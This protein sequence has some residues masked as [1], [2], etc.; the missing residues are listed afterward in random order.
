MYCICA[1]II[2]IIELIP[3]LKNKNQKLF[4][5]YVFVLLICAVLFFLRN[6][7]PS[8]AST[9]LKLVGDKNG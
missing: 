1:L 8:I 2:S 4:I 5:I 9:L 3:L 7:I 6:Y